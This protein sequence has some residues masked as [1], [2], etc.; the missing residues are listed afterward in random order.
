[1]SEGDNYS[2]STYSF[3]SSHG[4]HLYDQDGNAIL[5]QTSIG[6]TAPYTGIYYVFV[7]WDPGLYYSNVRFTMSVDYNIP[8]NVANDYLTGSNIFA[9]S[10]HDFVVG[11]LGQDYLRGED[12]NDIINGRDGFDDING[13]MGDDSATGGLGADWV[14]GGK[15]NDQLKGDQ[16]DDIVYGNL[17]SDSCEGGADNDLVRGGQ[18][19]DFLS[20]GSGVDW[21]SGD[22]GDDTVS[23]GSGADTFN[24]FAGAGRDRV[25][26]FSIAE[27]DRVKIEPGSAYSVGQIGAD[28][29]IYLADGSSMTLVGVQTSTL[30]S[31][32]IFVA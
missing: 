30:P 31:G 7:Y 3:F 8:N 25:T 26:D 20:G 18:D 13:N 23:G 6:Y 27:G 28:T 21:L 2:F 32:W 29:V 19:N 12:G 16:G 9:G 11:T 17:G 22:R 10:G 24:F 1:M 14:V 15:D 5:F 4:A